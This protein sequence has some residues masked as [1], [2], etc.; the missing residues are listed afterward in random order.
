MTADELRR[1]AQILVD[2]G[3]LSHFVGDGSMPLHVSIH[4]NGWGPFP[5]PN[6]Y[7][8]EHVH[9]PWEGLY[10]RQV[11]TPQAVAAAMPPFHD[12][13]CPIERRVGAYLMGDW[14]TVVPFYEL[15]KSG[16]FQPGVAKGARF[17]V[18]G[19]A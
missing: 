3:Q 14:R 16:A 2:I 5:N 7:T 17:T 12:C 18:T 8:Q 13:A 6:N 19:S 1:Q 15:E 9:S 4:Y 11:V 10:V